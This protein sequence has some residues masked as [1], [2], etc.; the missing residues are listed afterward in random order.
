MHEFDL[1]FAVIIESGDRLYRVGCNILVGAEVQFI[2]TAGDSECVGNSLFIPFAMVAPAHSLQSG[3]E[4][5][6][7]MAGDDYVLEDNNN[8]LEKSGQV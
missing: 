3:R 4:L 7:G 1:A 8:C 6:R 2:E 5:S